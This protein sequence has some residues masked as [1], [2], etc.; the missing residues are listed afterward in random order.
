MTLGRVPR[1]WVPHD[2]MGGWPVARLPFAAGLGR[3]EEKKEEEEEEEVVYE[4]SASG[5]TRSCSPLV[6]GIDV[7]PPSK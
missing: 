1:P 4:S 5:K 7:R 2:V 3:M 6:S